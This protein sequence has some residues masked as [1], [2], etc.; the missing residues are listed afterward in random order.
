M[1]PGE[2]NFGYDHRFINQV[3][4]RPH[5]GRRRFSALLVLPAAS[6]EAQNYDQADVD[7]IR[8]I[9]GQSGLSEVRAWATTDPGQW[10][11]GTGP[12][13]NQKVV[14]DSSRA[15][16]L[17]MYNAGLSGS[18]EVSPLTDLKE[19]RVYYNSDLTGITGLS[20]LTDLEKLYVDDTGLTELNV[21]KNTKLTSLNLSN[22]DISI[23]DVSQN[24]LLTNLNF[25]ESKIS[26]IDVRNNTLLEF[27]DIQYTGISSLDLT[28]N[29]NLLNLNAGDTGL[30]S[31]DVTNNPKLFSLTISDTAIS[32]LDLSKNLELKY[33][34]ADHSKL[35]SL[36]LR[37]N[38]DLEI[39]ELNY[40]DITSLDLS[41]N[42]K[43][44]SLDIGYTGLNNQT[45][46]LR[47]HKDLAHIDISGLSSLTL[48]TSKKLVNLYTDQETNRLGS[49][50]AGTD[51]LNWTGRTSFQ[52]WQSSN[53][54]D[55]LVSNYKLDDRG[56]THLEAHYTLGDVLKSI[57]K[58]RTYQVDALSK[59]LAAE[60]A[61]A[62][63]VAE[64]GQ[65]VALDG[66]GRGD[67]I[68]DQGAATIIF[69]TDG[70]Y[71]LKLM[72]MDEYFID[73]HS[74]YY[75][76]YFIV[77]QLAEDDLI[78]GGQTFSFNASQMAPVLNAALTQ[79]VGGLIMNAAA[80]VATADSPAEA[81]YIAG[82]LTS[83][84]VSSGVQAGQSQ[85][86]GM[87]GLVM[88]HLSPPPAS[89]AAPAAGD[90]GYYGDRARGDDWR[91]NFRL[92]GARGSLDGTRRYQ[93]YD[94]TSTAGVLTMDRKVHSNWRVGAGLMIGRT[95]LEWDS[96]GSNT[97]G[98]SIGAALFTRYEEGPFFA[99]LQLNLGRT[100]T[101]NE[102]GIPTFNLKAESDYDLNW[103]GAGLFTGYT[104]GLGGLDLTP[105]LGLSYLHFSTDAVIEHGAGDLNLKT[106]KQNQDSLEASFDLNLAYPIQ[107]ENVLFT[108]RLNLGVAT[109]LADKS[110]S[111][112]T[113]FV[114]A[115][116]LGYF[117]SESA[118]LS[119]TRFLAGAGLSADFSPNI[120]LS[121]DYSGSFQ[122]RH[123]LHEGSLTVNLT[124]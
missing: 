45:L 59:N 1:M 74:V 115:P 32:S 90:G 113:S 76:D 121:L 26:A 87:T 47:N 67:M 57:T 31:L 85:V 99:S 2:E 46:D 109:E 75:D 16:V 12:F 106:R 35:A 111:T 42:L 61:A 91:L 22:T 78:S 44:N 107:T 88:S 68:Y 43:L 33:L 60:V 116:Q 104:F 80:A 108:P 24:T 105:R 102:R 29:T 41:Q 89:G 73:T 86:K 49:D 14:W 114:S 98:Q 71:H 53:L 103:A 30:A 25:G 23:L 17:Y 97:K 51:R 70:I 64:T 21:S 63:K 3:K 20:S 77:G 66:Y 119:R 94:Q 4:T 50:F 84:T 62:A 55:N 5:F 37:Q 69:D 18:I 34:D 7:A 36:D 83:E 123:Q 27:L 95:E 72:V 92:S 9:A 13:F 52:Q 122:S 54:R 8:A 82:Q 10:Q 101:H 15:S 6:A 19:M 48:Q 117:S 110:V 39:L 79:N 81:A 112:R 56:K 11:I 124:W 96:Y 38:K 65:T 93:G 118:D 40:N 28:K 100:K 120:G 58:E